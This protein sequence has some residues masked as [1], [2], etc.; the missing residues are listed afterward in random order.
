M[1]ID[2]IKQLQ[3]QVDMYRRSQ[4]SDTDKVRRELIDMQSKLINKDAIIQ[5]LHQ[6]CEELLSFQVVEIPIYAS[7]GA[8]GLNK[9]KKLNKG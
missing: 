6:K 2:T 4:H 9:K 3:D 5:E 1:K 8:G 7:R